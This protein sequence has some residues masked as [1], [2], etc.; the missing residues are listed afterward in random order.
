MKVIR[1][2]IDDFSL[3]PHVPNDVQKDIEKVLQ[4]EECHEVCH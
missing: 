1:L 3:I 2:E 4:N